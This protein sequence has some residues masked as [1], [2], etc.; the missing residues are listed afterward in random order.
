MNLSPTQQILIGFALFVAVNATA[1][2]LIPADTTEGK[3]VI[4]LVSSASLW[5]QRLGI[6]TTPPEQ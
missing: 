3:W 1:Q 2:G 4:L 5:L 6:R